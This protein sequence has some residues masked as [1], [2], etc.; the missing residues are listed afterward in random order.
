MTKVL[1]IMAVNGFFY[2][3]SNPTW[4]GD[5]II[6]L[7]GSI[8]QILPYFLKRCFKRH[9]PKELRSTHDDRM[10]KIV[11]ENGTFPPIPLQKPQ[12]F[13]RRLLAVALNTSF[14]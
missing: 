6:S 12:I 3:Q 13:F 9:R 2:G 10:E 8:I 5:I 11:K 14:P 7:Y 1:T 4:Q